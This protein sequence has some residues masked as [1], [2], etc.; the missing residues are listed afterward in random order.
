MHCHF[1]PDYLLATLAAADDDHAARCGHHTRQV[2]AGL[3]ARRSAAGPSGSAAAATAGV[4]WE[5]YTA[6]NGSD[7]PGTLV[8]SADQPQAGDPAVDEAALGV[9][10][11]LALYTDLGRSSYDD[12]GATVLATVHYEQDYDNAFWN[13]SQLVCGDGDGKV[14]DRF[15]K[16]IDVLGHEISHALT[17][18]TANF[19]YSGQSGALNESISD[20]F[21][22]CVKQR[23]L[24]QSAADADW[25]IGE[26]IFLPGINGVAL[27]SMKEP[28]T[29]YDDPKI[30]KDPQVGSMADYVDTTDD[31]GGVHINSGIPNKAFYLAATVIGGDAWQ[32]AGT[33]WYAALTSGIGADAT[34]AD[35]AQATVTAAGA[36]S[37]AVRAA[38]E[39]VGVL[40]E[41]TPS[42]GATDAPAASVNRL[43]VRRTGGFAGIPTEGSIDLDAGD[44]RA[45][46]ARELLAHADLAATTAGEPGADRF[47]YDFDFPRQA[48]GPGGPVRVHETALTPE[49][50]RLAELALDR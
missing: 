36:Q 10:Q 47:V 20:V 9:D 14:F 37:D 19:T 31:D 25:L 45:A 46:E 12:K 40:G 30:G 15:T 21:G 24:G 43:T 50:R 6:A 5:V 4:A 1:I 29:A 35:F 49:L 26:G 3:R 44:E 7:L 48:A 42:S 17:Q 34:F 11:T 39:Q 13:G 2:D 38:W 22:I 33:I 32:G 23:H 28:G 41:G 16:P 27:R 18:Y 8:R